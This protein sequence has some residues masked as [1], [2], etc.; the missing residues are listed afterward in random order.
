VGFAWYQRE[1]WARLRELAADV[2]RLEEDYDAWLISAERTFAVVKSEGLAVERVP[3]DVQE[4]AAWCAREG[5]QFDSKARSEYVADLM[6]NR[7][8]AFSPS[9][10]PGGSG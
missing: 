6:R 10:E 3:V 4:M 8:S 7:A 5:R 2:D 1:Q 9:D